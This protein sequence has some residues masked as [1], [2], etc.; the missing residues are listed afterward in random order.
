MTPEGVGWVGEQVGIIQAIP[1]SQ[2][3]RTNEQKKTG[4]NKTK[5]D[6]TG[7]NKTRQDK[8]RQKKTKQDPPPKKRI[9]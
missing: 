9:F 4:I 6:K 7:Q 1:D 2:S 3:E 5:Q 8:R